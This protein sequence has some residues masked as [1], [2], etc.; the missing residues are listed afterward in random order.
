MFQY[1][2]LLI[3]FLGTLFTAYEGYNRYLDEKQ[4]NYY[5][6]TIKNL[7]STDKEEVM[8][9]IATLGVY[10]NRRKYKK[11]TV[12][13]LINILYTELDYDIS[14]AIIG[15]LI[16]SGKKREVQYIASR[17]IEINRNFFIQ[18]DPL[19]QREED[20]RR[21]IEEAGMVKNEPKNEVA[22]NEKTN[23]EK[24]TGTNNGK[25]EQLKKLEEMNQFRLKWH[26]LVTA[27]VLSMILNK[28]TKL[29][30]GPELKLEF[31]QNDF[32]YCYLA[33]FTL[34]G[35]KISHSAISSGNIMDLKLANL[36]RIYS[37]TFAYS[38]ISDCTFSGGTIS[39]SSFC[40]CNFENVLFDN[41]E[42]RDSF[43]FK[44]RLRNCNFK[45]VKGLKPE[46]F[47]LAEIFP[48]TNFHGAISN[49]EI[50][51]LTPERVRDYLLTS[52]IPD[53][54]Y[55]EVIQYLPVT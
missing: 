35:F 34:E 6:E 37:S 48:D 20:I 49:E 16:Q 8:A 46:Q 12:D 24:Q 39:G 4:F 7:F 25:D 27:D 36:D 5:K 21:R 42:F 3:G 51:Q 2:E 19:K 10:A 45:S 28:A 13:T 54:R 50:V 1:I 47:Y 31:Y 18:S 14:N 43:F 40:G 33:G 23:G 38:L 29:G 41:V 32:N 22:A 11:S 44:A 55:N 9:A 15:V 26:K 52:S 53:Y 30:I 17:L